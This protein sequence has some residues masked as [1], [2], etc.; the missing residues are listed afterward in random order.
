M[1]LTT[2]VLLY[3]LVGLKQPKW[4]QT[5]KN[6]PSWFTL[7]HSGKLGKVESV[8]YKI[9]GPICSVTTTILVA[10]LANRPLPSIM[11]SLP[12]SHQP[13]SIEKIK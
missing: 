9:R 8:S 1:I 12:G 2:L 13:S 7:V 10:G 5:V 11:R 3:D 6:F 4:G